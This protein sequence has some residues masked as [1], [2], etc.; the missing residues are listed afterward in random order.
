MKKGISI[1]VLIGSSLSVAA[2]AAADD[3]RPH[4]PPPEA[5]TAC[6]SKQESDTCSVQ[7]RDKTL[8]GKCVMSKEDSKLFCMPNDMSPPPPSG[9][10]L[11]SPPS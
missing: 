4:G 2:I 7:F 5:F 11:P 3:S 9:T 8:D 10:P 1:L 6:A